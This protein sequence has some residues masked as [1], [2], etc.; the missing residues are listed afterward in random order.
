M[1]TAVVPGH[2]QEDS[3]FCGKLV[4]SSDTCLMVEGVGS[5]LTVV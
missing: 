2:C 3:R 5:L 4:N 1:W